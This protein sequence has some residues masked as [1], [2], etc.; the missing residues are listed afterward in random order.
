MS[1]LDWLPHFSYLPASAIPWRA[2][3]MIFPSPR[4]CRL[5]QNRLDVWPEIDAEIVNLSQP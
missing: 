3:M 2:S 4:Q 5:Q 1:R